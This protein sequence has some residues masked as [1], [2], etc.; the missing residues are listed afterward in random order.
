MRPGRFELKQKT[1]AN[2][3]VTLVT[4]HDS[5]NSVGV[6]TMAKLVKTTWGDTGHVSVSHST[7]YCH[8]R[9]TT[10]AIGIAKRPVPFRVATTPILPPYL[11]KYE[12][13][14]RESE[15]SSKPTSV[16]TNNAE[17]LH[18]H[19]NYCRCQ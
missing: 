1:S 6:D 18:D 19:C 7:N 9:H 4:A 15:H 5:S 12:A 13:P 2:V 14:T 11:T 8:Y 10:K 17:L 16:W 3:V